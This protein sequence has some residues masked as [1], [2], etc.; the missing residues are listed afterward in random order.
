[1][2]ESVVSLIERLRQAQASAIDLFRRNQFQAALSEYETAIEVLSELAARPALNQ[3]AVRNSFLESLNGRAAVLFRMRRWDEA[4]T[5]WEYLLQNYRDLTNADPSA[6][7]PNVAATLNNLANLV[8]GRGRLGEAEALYAEAL[9]IRRNLAKEDPSAYLPDV[10]ATLNNLANLVS[11]RGRLGEAEALYAEALASY[12]NLTKADPSTYLPDVAATLNNLANLVSDRGRLGEAEGLYAE[13]L[14]IRRNLAKA[15]PTAYLPDVAGT[16]NNLANLVS[17]RGRLGEAEALFVEALDSY[18]NLAKADPSAY[19]PNVAATLNNLAAL[20]SGR[21]RLGEAEAL[22]AEA[23]AIR[24]KLAKEDPSAYLPDV[25][26]TL[27]NLAISVSGRGRLGEAEA[28]YAEALAIYEDLAKVAAD[29]WGPDLAAARLRRRIGHFSDAKIVLPAPHEKILR[30]LSVLHTTWVSAN[31]ASETISLE[32]MEKAILAETGWSEAIEPDRRVERVLANHLEHQAW[33]N[34]MKEQNQAFVNSLRAK[35]VR[36]GDAIAMRS[37]SLSNTTASEDE[38]MEYQE[39]V[40][41]QFFDSALIVDPEDR[42]RIDFRRVSLN[43]KW[44][45]LVRKARQD[46]DWTEEKLWEDLDATGVVL[47]DFLLS[48]RGTVIRLRLPGGE[49]RLSELKELSLESVQKWFLSESGFMTALY[50]Y[51]LLANQD[52]EQVFRSL[53]SARKSVGNAIMPALRNLLADVPHGGKLLILP[54]KYFHNLDVSTVPDA[55]SRTLLDDYDVAF[56]PSIA[57][58]LQSVSPFEKWKSQAVVDP[59]A[60]KGENPILSSGLEAAFV[61]D[62]FPPQTLSFHEST[63]SIV[64]AGEAE[65]VWFSCH[66]K[67]DAGS[68]L[69][70]HVRINQINGEEVKLRAVELLGVATPFP[71]ARLAV[72]S[73]CSTGEVSIGN[74]NEESMSV[75]A[76]F[77]AAG[78]P[79]VWTALWPVGDLPTYLLMTRAAKYLCEGQSPSLALRAAK[80]WLRDSNAKQ[81]LD[82]HC[83][84][85]EDSTSGLKFFADAGYEDV[86]DY[87]RKIELVLKV[88]GGTPFRHEYYWAGFQHLGRHDVPR[89]LA[90]LAA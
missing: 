51:R 34:P 19:L 58:Y 56:T 78:I 31:E 69:E 7:L 25:A 32:Q 22:F 79:M 21:G 86:S 4:E 76:A 50:R 38:T 37:A 74:L 45:P 29:A 14:E 82:H 67:Y 53:S 54:S 13:A 17:G 61:D 90:D 46:A 70:S 41:Y 73:A 5:I 85:A 63:K 83:I 30:Y 27:N 48:D 87:S 60:L 15:D 36:L 11:D 42:A 57:S 62:G 47:I 52:F 43:T 88:I 18:R 8:R 84:V 24:R 77:L 75:G 6:H 26:E 71:S 3:K 55:H 89:S 16:L 40:Q 9:E 33:P 10:A 65:L 20:V 28:L 72:L 81:L 1:M 44:R 49:F 23:L 59:T 80:H 66:G 39:F 2:R 12:R 68:P 64:N 35:G